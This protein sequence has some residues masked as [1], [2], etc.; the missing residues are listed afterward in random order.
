[1]AYIEG[2]PGRYDTL[3]TKRHLWLILIACT[4]LGGLAAWSAFDQSR[5]GQGMGWTVLGGIVL[6]LMV[7]SLKL[8]AKGWKKLL[9]PARYAQD[10]SGDKE[11]A[12]NLAKL[13]DA[14]FVMHDFTFEFFHVHHLVISPRGIF[15]IV[16]LPS[17]AELSVRNNVLFAGGES[18]ETLTGRMW[19]ICH[20]VNIIVHKGFQLQIM[21]QPILVCSAGRIPEIDAFDGGIRILSLDV[22]NREICSAEEESMR[23]EEAASIAGYIAHRY[24]QVQ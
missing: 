13:D 5:M 19:R 10:L 3:R 23:A 1:M 21:P 24:L 18:L 12:D 17:E 2:Y 6:L 16:R 20:L 4:T 7:V 15:V 14:H 22:L 9:M 11:V 8:N